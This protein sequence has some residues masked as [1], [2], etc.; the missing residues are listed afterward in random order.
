MFDTVKEILPS[1]H[2]FVISSSSPAAF[3]HAPQP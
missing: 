2:D 1:L 3:F